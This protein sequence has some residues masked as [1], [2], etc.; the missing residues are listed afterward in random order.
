MYTFESAS[1]TNVVIES[2]V[3]QKWYFNSIKQT[4]QL[5]SKARITPRQKIKE[6]PYK[7][8]KPNNVAQRWKIKYYNMKKNKDIIQ[9][10]NTNS[11]QKQ[12]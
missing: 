4:S 10:K 11:T 3:D 2:V 1:L 8:G 6:T 12:K 9:A 5:E 7:D